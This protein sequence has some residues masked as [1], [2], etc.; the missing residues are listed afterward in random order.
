MCSR[1]NAQAADAGEQS[2]YRCMLHSH[3]I[4]YLAI[5]GSCILL[6]HTVLPI[7]PVRLT[8]RVSASAIPPFTPP[9]VAPLPLVLGTAKNVCNTSRLEHITANSAVSA[10]CAWITTGEATRASIHAPLCWR[11]IE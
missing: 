2:T 3:R 4:A 1:S 11:H 5:W 7:V 6:L 9:H 10:C 8:L